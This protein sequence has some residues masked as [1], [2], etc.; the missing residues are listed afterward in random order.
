MC[1]LFQTLD[2]REN[3]DLVMPPKPPEL[4]NGAN[5][6]FYNIDFSLSHQLQLAGA[7]PPPSSTET[8]S[9]SRV[10]GFHLVVAMPWSCSSAHNC[11][12]VWSIFTTVTCTTP[13]P[14]AL[15]LSLDLMQ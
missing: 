10:F 1:T 6:E 13:E 2:V 11:S 4:M 8:T 12:V 5:M 9:T 14:V 3:P 7:A 15:T